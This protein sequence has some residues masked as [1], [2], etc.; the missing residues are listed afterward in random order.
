MMP[1]R[2]TPM[3]SALSGGLALKAVRIC[4]WMT[5][6]IRLHRIR[7]TSIR[8]RKMRGEETLKG[9]SSRA[10]CFCDVRPFSLPKPVSYY[11][12]GPANVTQVIADS[13]QMP[14]K[15]SGSAPVPTPDVLT[16]GFQQCLQFALYRL[17]AG[18]DMLL[19]EHGVG[20]VDIGNE[21]AGLAQDD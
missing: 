9:S 3:I 6:T 12:T 8:T 10:M 13:T 21:A 4:G 18:N 17:V 19:G 11:G 7:K 16:G 20:A 15:W 1:I 2:R 14:P 5:T